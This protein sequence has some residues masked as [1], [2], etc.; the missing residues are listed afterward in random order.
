MSPGDRYRFATPELG[1]TSMTQGIQMWDRTTGG[2]TFVCGTVNDSQTFRAPMACAPA[3]PG[4]GYRFA[5]FGRGDTLDTWRIEC[6]DDVHGFWSTDLG[7]CEGLGDNVFRAPT[8]SRPAT[9]GE[10][11]RYQ[12]AGER[13][14]PDSELWSITTNQWKA[15]LTS[16][17][18]G[19]RCL[20]SDRIRVPVEDIDVYVDSGGITFLSNTDFGDKVLTDVKA[21]MDLI[22]LRDDAINDHAECYGNVLELEAQLESELARCEELHELAKDATKEY[23]DFVE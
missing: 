5:T 3:S 1:D 16:A 19:F 12:E 9:A 20:H 6:W 15:M 14:Q 22:A 23:D 18:H 2:W 4:K 10:G 21:G 11:Y 17:A 7:G 13:L 8:L